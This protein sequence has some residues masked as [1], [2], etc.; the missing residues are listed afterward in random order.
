MSSVQP[1]NMAPN[2]APGSIGPW[3][4]P[5]ALEEAPAGLFPRPP[6]TIKPQTTTKPTPPADSNKPISYEDVARQQAELYR[7]AGPSLSR[8]ERKQQRQEQTLR[9]A[10]WGELPPPPPPPRPC[11]QQPDVVMV[12]GPREKK[13]QGA[14]RRE[15]V[16][17]RDNR[18]KH[19]SIHARRARE[20]EEMARRQRELFLNAGS[21]KQKKK[22]RM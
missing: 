3:K 22:P 17:V 5:Y 19:E 20:A 11:S 4:K 16:E 10:F 18:D 2:A 14:N 9:E 12:M 21:A 8:K 13:Q 7:N 6:S 15:V 1:T